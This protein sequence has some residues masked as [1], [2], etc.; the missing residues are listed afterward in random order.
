MAD[1]QPA[2]SWDF[3]GRTLAI[4]GAT[5][6][7]AG[8]ILDAAAGPGVTLVLHGRDRDATE[9]LAEG[10]SAKGATTRVVIGDLATEAERVAAEIAAAGEVDVLVNNAGVYTAGGVLGVGLDEVRRSF[11]VNA[12][13]ALATLQS[14]MPGMNERGFGRV[15]MISSGGGSFGEGLAPS[16]AAYSISKA[17]MN[18][19]T[20]MAAKAARGGVKANAMCPGWVRTKMGGSGASRSPEQGADTALWLAA[21]GPD[22]PNGGYFRDRKPVPW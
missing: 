7:I 14:V 11:E 2:S 17:A 22:G 1:P 13:A 20:L 9:K 4:T 19:T 5:G 12:V 3:S 15:V 21:L 8:A 18:A 6:G 10:L 16:H